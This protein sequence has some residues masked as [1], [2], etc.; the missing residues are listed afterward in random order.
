MKEDIM[1]FLCTILGNS[2]MK[3]AFKHSGKGE[4]MA[5]SLA[6]VGGL[7]GSPPGIAVGWTFGDP[8]GARMNSGHLPIPQI[9]MKLPPVEQQ[10]LFK[11]DLAIIRYLDW[12]D[13]VQLTALVMGNDAL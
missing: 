7:V 2:K 4:L 12:M 6:F 5:G 8:L 13:V 10:K 9:I 1:K 3:A 11:E